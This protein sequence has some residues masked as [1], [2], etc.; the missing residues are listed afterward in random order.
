MLFLSFFYNFVMVLGYFM[1]A[2]SC[3]PQCFIERDRDRIGK[4]VATAMRSRHWDCNK[5]LFISFI[6]V[7]W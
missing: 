1:T 7:F 2:K 6:K 5:L 4:I 3:L